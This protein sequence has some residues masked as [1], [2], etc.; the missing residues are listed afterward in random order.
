MGAR[1]KKK[2]GLLYMTNNDV[3]K[4]NNVLVKKIDNRRE[5]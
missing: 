4:R 1:L 2:L 3:L 5:K